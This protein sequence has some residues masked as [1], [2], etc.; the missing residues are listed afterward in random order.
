MSENETYTINDLMK[1]IKL[2]GKNV[3][4]LNDMIKSI[5][6]KLKP[7]E[8]EQQSTEEKENIEKILEKKG[9]GRPTGS[10]ETKQKKYCEMLNSNKI[11][12][13]KQHTLEF[14]KVT[15]N[16]DGVYVLFE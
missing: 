16:D 9:I 4:T 10:Y 5:D 15:K 3:K 7:V 11:K 12:Q 1:K 13:S 14:Y 6:E 8:R 2:V